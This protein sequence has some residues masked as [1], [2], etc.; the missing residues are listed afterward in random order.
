MV[1]VQRQ[2]KK[3][4]AIVMQIERKHKEGWRSFGYIDELI[5]RIICDLIEFRLG[6]EFFNTKIESYKIRE[7]T[8]IKI[9]GNL[10]SAKS[11]QVLMKLM[12]KFLPKYHGFE[13]LGVL[14]Y[15]YSEKKMYTMYDPDN[16]QEENQI[17]WVPTDSGICGEIIKDKKIK[18]QNVIN[19]KMFSPGVDA[20]H[21]VPYIKN[22]MYA[23]IFQDYPKNTMLIGIMQFVNKPDDNE[24]EEE[25]IELFNRMSG[26]YGLMV[27]KAIE[28]HN[29]L[30]TLVMIKASTN[31]INDALPKNM[32]E[33]DDSHIWHLET[34]FRGFH[35]IINE[36]L[37]DKREK[38]LKSLSS[39]NTLPKQK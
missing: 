2:D 24:I 9:L 25:D 10:L 4:I 38:A 29:I 30:N 3:R 23:P 27:L 12:R 16:E 6:Y 13:G 1:S 22:L 36:M 33:E 21:G 5:F 17:E 15:V 39:A 14:F 28:K 11:Q 35:G 34:A 31:S 26:I 32:S 19:R 7:E 37:E 8:L 20:V 18:V